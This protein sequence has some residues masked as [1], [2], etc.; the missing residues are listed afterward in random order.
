M[1]GFT[2]VVWLP[3]GAERM[4]ADLTTGPGAA[5]T[6]GAANAWA[7]I[8]AA[9]LQT[10]AEFATTVAN[11]R[12][13]WQGGTADAALGKLGEFAQWLAD[14]ATAVTKAAAT[15]GTAAGAFTIAYGTMPSLAE[16]GLT[17]S[18]KA[19]AVAVPGV[20]AG[21]L[22]TAEAAER[23]QDLR[24]AATMVAYES[25]C[26]GAA[27]PVE[28]PVPPKLTTG[29]VDTPGADG[30]REAGVAQ[31]GQSIGEAAVSTFQAGAGAV[32]PGGLQSVVSSVG[33]VAAQVSAGASGLANLTSA[34]A[35]TLGSVVSGANPGSG[36]APAGQVGVVG[37]GGA[38]R[39]T[40]VSGATTAP[41]GGYSTGRAG[42]A[43]GGGGV[44]LGVGGLGVGGL[45]VG[46]LSVGG[47][48]VGGL[49]SGG[50][51]PGAHSV[52]GDLP[53]TGQPAS[54]AVPG[55]GTSATASSPM[56]APISAGRADGGEEEHVA[57]R[58]FRH[59]AELEV[60]DGQL[61]SPAVIGAEPQ[62]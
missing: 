56:G 6:F 17:K 53:G 35:H 41:A 38:P 7:N 62:P 52:V 61:V 11:L 13:N 57:R 10:S 32:T 49:G 15:T 29:F 4:S 36:G 42:A 9:L 21:A 1:V 16:I 54:G 59:T 23:A 22:A 18:A 28:F 31:P 5:G 60:L 25:A 8:D 19:A 26:G 48:G 58:E 37:T 2:G 50:L 43:V 47:L 20:G 3:R 34:A 33:T 46:G 27:M 45:G 51:G 44:G 12:S 55:G 39:G 30:A 24:A 40:R 14:A